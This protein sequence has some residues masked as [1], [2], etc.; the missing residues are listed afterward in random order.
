MNE[1]KGIFSSVVRDSISLSPRDA[2][3][4]VLQFLK[5]AGTSNDE[6]EIFR[7]CWSKVHATNQAF[8]RSGPSDPGQFAN[9]LIKEC[10]QYMNSMNQVEEYLESIVKLN[11]NVYIMAECKKNG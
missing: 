9:E 5:D 7:R 3:L 10:S 1:T 2:H 6:L 11:K 4:K 8:G